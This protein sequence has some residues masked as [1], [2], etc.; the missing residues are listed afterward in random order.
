MKR[1]YYEC[2]SCLEQFKVGHGPGLVVRYCPLCGT[3]DLE[4]PYADDDT[5]DEIDAEIS[6]Y[7]D[8]D[9]E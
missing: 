4:H 9:E 3:S 7:Y 2:D 6:K 5:L 8:D 1:A